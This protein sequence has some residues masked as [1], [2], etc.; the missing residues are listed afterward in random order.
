MKKGNI[1]IILLFISS[2]S[3]AQFSSFKAN[4][5]SNT[6]VLGLGAGVSHSE[7]DY[8]N[9]DFSFNGLASAEYFF[10]NSSDLFL[11]LKLETGIT[12]LNADF[13]SSTPYPGLDINILSLGPS[14]SLNY[15][16]AKDIYPYAAIGPRYLWYSDFTTISLATEIGIRVLLSNYFSISGSAAFN[17]LSE[18]NL[19][20]IVVSHSSNDFYSTYSIGISYAVDLTISNDLDGD[21]IVNSED[22]CPEQQEDFDGF[23]DNDGCP[24]FDN[25]SD[26]IV[27]IKDN[28]IDEAEDFDG[29]EDHDGCPDPDNDQ[30]GILDSEDNCPDLKEDF[31][32]FEDSDGCPELDNDNDGI[33]DANDDC[34]N[35][36]ETFNGY[37]DF[38]GCPDELPENQIVEEKIEVL[39]KP[40]NNII[41]EKT[42]R[43]SIPNE[44]VLEGDELFSSNSSNIKSSAYNKLNQIASQMLSN[45]DFK[46]RIEGHLDNSG[47][48]QQLRALSTEWANSVM[49]YFVSKGLSPKSFQVVGLAD[50]F[51]LAPNS[52]I[53]GK[54]KNRRIVIKRIR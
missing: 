7:T 19:D 27:D 52:S 20:K 47:S 23:E 10:E 22:Q 38:D 26:G 30:D 24:E 16:L 40:E 14:V 6:L 9:F 1:L 45:S 44:F 34:P 53:Y 17:F 46:W 48:S 41:K 33:V 18:D 35:K 28:C 13:N 54:L 12:N 25:D 36:P 37:E 29:F 21:G 51:P 31:D 42:T 39:E 4:K 3:F 15:Q 49:N 11:G 2:L 5:F 32:G 50:K 43:L 8:K